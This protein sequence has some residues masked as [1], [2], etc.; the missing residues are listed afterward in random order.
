MKRIV[1]DQSFAAAGPQPVD[2]QAAVSQTV[3]PWALAGR[4]P[5]HAIN[6]DAAA[7][8]PLRA[9]ARA[10][11][12]A[13]L[14]D[15]VNPSSV[16]FFGV[17]ARQ[18]V[19]ESRA[20]LAAALGARPS[21]VIFT[22]GGTEANNLALIGLAL[23]KPRGRHVVTTAIEHPSVLESCRYLERVFGFEVTLLPVDRVGRINPSEA[24]AVLRPD[25]TLLSI[26]LANAE[27]GTVQAINEIAEQARLL[28]IPVHTDAVQAAAS[29]PV[30]FGSTQLASER[31]A[32]TDQPSL[33]ANAWPGA[34]VQ[35]MSLASHKFGGPQ[36]VG[37]LLLRRGLCIEPVLHGGGQEGGLR[38]GT[39]NVA[40]IAGFAAAVTAS[41]SAVGSR[42]LE[43]AASRDA[44]VVRMLSGVPGAQLTG[45]STE[46]LPGHASFVVPGV[47]GES[48]L[49]AL[50][51][52]GFAVSSGS[53]CAAGNDEPSPVLLAL[54]IE[55]MVAQTAIRFSIPSPLSSAAIERIVAVL[56][57][58]VSTALGLRQPNA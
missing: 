29:L 26:G 15:A 33:Q 3:G 14:N 8:S 41:L 10:A 4:V 25:T 7:T 16:H 56:R 51:V 53:A 47:S 32:N 11:M 48:L 46:R 34:A 21:E 40:G 54:G 1:T 12:I 36:G 13:A 18:L 9:E 30:S 58:E 27:I 22:S 5:T 49:V 23:G 38:S 35:A 39:E 6:L 37:A 19:D 57:G 45:H 17:R 50:D 31:E 52:A 28:G 55:P 20:A 43:L 44:L 24:A 42:A 2:P